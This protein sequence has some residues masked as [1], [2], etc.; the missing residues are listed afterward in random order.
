MHM[1]NDVGQVQSSGAA[2][3]TS[4]GGDEG[5]RDDVVAWR[6]QGRCGSRIKAG[7]AEWGAQIR[8]QAQ[9]SVISAQHFI[10]YMYFTLY[11]HFAR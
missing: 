5:I 3:A 10:H 1:G 6:Q 11:G 2:L 4:A 8:L 9:L 7:R